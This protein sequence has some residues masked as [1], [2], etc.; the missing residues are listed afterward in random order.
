MFT[1]ISAIAPASA[2][3]AYTP[4]KF[5]SQSTPAGQSGEVPITVKKLADGTAYDLTGKQLLLTITDADGNVIYAKQATITNAVGGIG[6]F[7]FEVGDTDGKAGG[8]TYDVWL[9]DATIVPNGH[10]QLVDVSAFSVTGV[11][12]TIAQ[13]VTVSPSQVPL[14]KGDAGPP[15]PQGPQGSGSQLQQLATVLAAR[16]IVKLGTEFYATDDA[17]NNRTNLATTEWVNIKFFGAVPGASG[18][19]TTNAAAIQQAIAVAC[20]AGGGFQQNENPNRGYGGTV[21]V[22]PGMYL[23]DPIDCS[24]TSGLTIQGAG[25]YNQFNALPCSSIIFGGTTSPFTDTQYVDGLGNPLPIMMDARDTFGFTLRNVAVGYDNTAFAGILIDCEHHPLSP[26]DTTYFF[27]DNCSIGGSQSNGVPI[28]SAAMLVNLN[29]VIT[30]TIRDSHFTGAQAGIKGRK[31]GWYSNAVTIHNCQFDNFPA[32][33]AAMMNAGENWRI[34]HCTGE[35]GNMPRM[36]YEDVASSSIGS[37]FDYSHNWY[38]DSGHTE[39]CVEFVGSMWGATLIG[40]NFAGASD[41]AVRISG[42]SKNIFCAAGGGHIDCQNAAIYGLTV[43]GW[44]TP[45]DGV[46]AQNAANVSGLFVFGGS[47]P[48]SSDAARDDVF[49]LCGHVQTWPAHAVN[50]TLTAGAAAGTAPPVCTVDPGGFGPSAGSSDAAGTIYI[51]AGTGCVAGYFARLAFAKQ[52]QRP[53]HVF[54]NYRTLGGDW[55][56]DAAPLQLLTH[57]D[58]AG[59]DI[60]TKSIPVDGKVYLYDFWVVE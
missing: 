29:M 7:P 20:N 27:I 41:P 4:I 31:N 52:Y 45:N 30:S 38:G 10:Y 34:S 18:N 21:Y 57:A 17:T 26:N 16:P 40:N 19:P 46:V 56:N 60:Y 53:P 22:P 28:T 8:Y 50:P 55:V 11:R 43:V 24:R 5:L 37:A 48:Q 13:A 9:T 15:G 42:G 54:L 12:G 36:Y 6:Y 33:G 51:Q 2:V 49:Q 3:D 47:G 14:A 58:V 25:G 59:V 39:P 32:P 44:A 23:S 35:G 1:S